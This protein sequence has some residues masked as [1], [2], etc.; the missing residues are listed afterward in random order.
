ME[1]FR[2]RPDQ[3]WMGDTSVLQ[4]SRKSKQIVEDDN[5]EPLLYCCQANVLDVFCSHKELSSVQDAFTFFT[6]F[7]QGFGAFNDSFF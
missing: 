7:K 1:V 5:N 4:D 3:H 2:F 6:A